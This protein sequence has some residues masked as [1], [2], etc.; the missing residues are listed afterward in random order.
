MEELVEFQGKVKPFK[1]WFTPYELRA[2]AIGWQLIN[3]CLYAKEFKPEQLRIIQFWYGLYCIVDHCYHRQSIVGP[4]PSDRTQWRKI[5]V[6][7][8]EAVL[9]PYILPAL[10]LEIEEDDSTPICAYVGTDGSYHYSRDEIQIAL[11]AL[12][13][14]IVTMQR[15]WPFLDREVFE[16]EFGAFEIP[17]PFEPLKLKVERK[18]VRNEVAGTLLPV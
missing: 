15:D 11:K 12:R 4:W 7:K 2:S 9:M 16:A 18:K 1:N 17:A 5:F 6:E 13:A 8:L 3:T 10:D 14:S